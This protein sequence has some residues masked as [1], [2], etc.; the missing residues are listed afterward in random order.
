LTGALASALCAFVESRLEIAAAEHDRRH[1]HHPKKHAGDVAMG[2][3]PRLG[4]F[5]F[6]S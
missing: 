1:Y 3:A 5:H 2:A 4:P 6:F